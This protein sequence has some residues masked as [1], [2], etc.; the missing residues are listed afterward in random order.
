MGLVVTVVS[1]TV[2]R[3]SRRDRR[4]LMRSW[5]SSSRR[6]QEKGATGSEEVGDGDQ[7]HQRPWRRWRRRMRRW[8]SGRGGA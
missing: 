5:V 2:L 8:G 7:A 6:R 3:A 4:V 1:P